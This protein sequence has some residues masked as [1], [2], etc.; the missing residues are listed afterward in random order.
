MPICGRYCHYPY[1]THRET[2]AR[3][4]NVI[5]PRSPSQLVVE[6]GFEPSGF[7]WLHHEQLLMGLLPGQ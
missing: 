3:S 7:Y 5:C 1:F 2:E 6:L 4:S